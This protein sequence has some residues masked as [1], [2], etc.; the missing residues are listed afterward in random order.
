MRVI[1]MCI[2]AG[3]W[4]VYGAIALGALIKLGNLSGFSHSLEG[5][6]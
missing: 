4:V 6:D 5:H 3:A 1:R 2:R